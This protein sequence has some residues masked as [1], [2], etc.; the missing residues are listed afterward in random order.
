MTPLVLCD[1]LDSQLSY[2]AGQR[3]MNQ[4]FHCEL[5]QHDIFGRHSGDFHFSNIESKD[6]LSE[7]HLIRATIA[8]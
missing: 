4:R 8:D 1:D 7:F 5:Q 6:C 2:A 3:I